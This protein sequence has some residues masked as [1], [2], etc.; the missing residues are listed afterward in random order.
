MLSNEWLLNTDDIV[1]TAVGVEG[2]LDRVEGY[3]GTISSA[4]TE[5]A[6]LGEGRGETDGVVEGEMERLM[7]LF[8]TFTTVEKV[9][10]DIVENGEEDTAG[11]VSGGT[12]VSASG[13]LDEGS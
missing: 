7:D 11:C 1:D 13:L 8:T 4:T 5:L 2:G 10:L 12:T 6:L 3:E 9:L